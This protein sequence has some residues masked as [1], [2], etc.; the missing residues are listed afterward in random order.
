M[1]KLK[2]QSRDSFMGKACRKG[3]LALLGYR[4]VMQVLFLKNSGGIAA[5]VSLRFKEEIVCL[6]KREGKGSQ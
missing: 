6:G 2:I 3:R 5:W 4:L 1:G